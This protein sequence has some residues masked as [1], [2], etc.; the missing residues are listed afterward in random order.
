MS[1]IGGILRY[2][3]VILIIALG[4]GVVL[5][6][7]MV[8]IPSLKIFGIHYL[9]QGSTINYT[10]N[11]EQTEGAKYSDFLNSTSLIVD[12]AGY[13]V[14][15]RPVEK[16]ELP[17]YSNKNNE[18]VDSFRFTVTNYM[19]GFAWGD[20][21]SPQT[22]FGQAVVNGEDVFKI[23]IKEP[24]GW[25]YHS[26]T[27]VEIIIDEDALTN[28]TLVING[29][30]SGDIALGS[31]IVYTSD[32]TISE[33]IKRLSVENLIVNAKK[34]DL[35]LKYVNIL[36]SIE[37]DK[38]EGTFQSSVDLLCP[39]NVKIWGGFGKVL[40][41]DI[42]SS[43]KSQSLSVEAT[44]SEIRF[45]NLYGDF[46][47][48]AKGGFVDAKNVH[49]TASVEGEDCKIKFGKVASSFTSKTTD[50]SVEVG[51]LCG[52][53]DVVTTKGSV[54]LGKTEQKVSVKTNNGNITLSEVYKTATAKS[55]YG[56]IDITWA[57]GLNWNSSSDFE[58]GDVFK[59]VIES[60]Y[61]SVY[62]KNVIGAISMTAIENGNASFSAN[63]L[64]IHAK[65]VIK[66]N[67]GN[68]TLSLPTTVPFYL[69]WSSVS[70]A[71]INYLGSVVSSEKS[72]EVQFL[73]GVKTDSDD[74][75]VTCAFHNIFVTT[76]NGVFKVRGMGY[77]QY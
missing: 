13:D 17:L 47:L 18:I 3:L 64:E 6:G 4:L 22:T 56:V 52:E 65:S 69:N 28:K 37:I 51:E 27:R 8:M 25:L 26:D 55:L 68:V 57:E 72:G 10:V 16:N 33:D 61:G 32:N 41:K 53:A 43:T 31:T 5:A 77:E 42:G 21:D 76:I 71:D 44:N 23:S 58:Y 12:A 20:V 11:E 70:N 7:A 75:S 19:T 9:G 66:T 24:D 40:L 46:N 1:V 36:R 67:A 50:G 39:V 49:R 34:G 59:T 73:G 63:Y 14:Y 30:G 35:N 2:T 60:K 48:V 29:T 54:I 45:D 38:T 74:S 15:I 62:V